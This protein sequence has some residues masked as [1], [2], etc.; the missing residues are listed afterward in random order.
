MHYEVEEH[1]MQFI[2]HAE[3]T[4]TSSK[5][6]GGQDYS[7]ISLWRNRLALHKVQNVSD[8]Q[9]EQSIGQSTHEK[10][11]EYVWVGHYS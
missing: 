5:Y 7:H 11:I 2:E 4:L 9:A 8:S 3:H 1:S 6:L 10:S